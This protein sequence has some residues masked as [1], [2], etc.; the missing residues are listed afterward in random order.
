MPQTLVSFDLPSELAD[1]LPDD[2]A[3][4]AQV[5]ELGLREWRIRRALGAFARGEGSLAFAAEQAGVSLREMVPLAYAHG[6]EPRVPSGTGADEPLS[7]E[8]AAD[9]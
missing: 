7:L 6:L 9:L 2:P 3:E 5:L 4:R 8:A 1:G